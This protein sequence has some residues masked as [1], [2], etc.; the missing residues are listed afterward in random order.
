MR[1]LVEGGEGIDPRR[2]R[3]R[4]VTYNIHR[5]IG[6]DRRFRPERVAHV[7]AEHDADIVLL[8]EVDDGV[9]RSRELDLAAVLAD[10]LDYPYYAVGHN[11]AVRQGGT[12]GNATL[13]RFPIERERNI[14]LTVGWRKRR[15]CQHTTIRLP[16]EEGSQEIEVFN[17]HLG[18]SAR[19]RRQQVGLLASSPEFSRLDHRSCC[20]VGGD[21]NDWRS[22]LRPFFTELLDFR[23]ATDRLTRGGPRSMRTY[24]SVTPRGGLDKV[25]YRGGILLRNIY[26]CRHQAARVASDHLPVIAEFDLRPGRA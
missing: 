3:L 10:A 13:S 8:Q 11:V 2:G 9:P 25:Y 19:E 18:L 12:Y 24:P 4:I 1:C 15:G 23:C 14:D 17:L 6:L 21:F 26:P 16:E 22:L 7:L 20:I 5:A